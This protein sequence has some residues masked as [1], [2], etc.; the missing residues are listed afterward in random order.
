MGM[1]IKKDPTKSKRP[2]KRGKRAKDETNGIP[3]EVLDSLLEDYQ[4]PED[5]LGSDGL[6]K[7]LTAALINRATEAELDHHLGY[8]RGESPPDRTTNRRNGKGEPKTVRTD[9]GELEIDTPRDREGTF[10]PQ[11][12]P[13]RQRHFNGFDDKILSMYARGMT[14]REIED[15]LRE[16][17]G[18]NVSRD[19]VSRVTAAVVGELKAWAGKAVGEAVSDCVSRRPGGENARPRLCAK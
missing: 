13:K 10:E 18:V 17:Y 15:H 14:T 19:L 12:V 7:R 6:L 2:R 5:M 16:I 4:S 1:T 9:Q 11:L 3:N 8:A